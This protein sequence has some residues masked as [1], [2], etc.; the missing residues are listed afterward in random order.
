MDKS[1]P[2]GKH[3]EGKQQQEFAAPRTEAL[4]TP[5]AAPSTT[6]P[7]KTTNLPSAA[8]APPAERK[9]LDALVAHVA[10]SDSVPSEL[11]QMM[12]LLRTK[13]PSMEDWDISDEQL[14]H[15]RRTV[16]T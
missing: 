15:K 2:K 12:N 8:T 13:S 7:P 1:K 10:S 3:S 16:E 9:L 4:P 5:P 6:F 14:R 11:Q